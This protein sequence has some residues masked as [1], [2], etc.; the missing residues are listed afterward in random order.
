MNKSNTIILRGI[1][2]MNVEPKIA[3]T[4]E[5]LLQSINN[6]NDKVVEPQTVYDKIPKIY[7]KNTW[8]KTTNLKCWKCDL[9]FKGIP[10]FIATKSLRDPTGNFCSPGCA[11]LYIDTEADPIHKWEMEMQLKFLH[12]E[13][14]GQTNVTIY[15]A[16]N[17]TRRQ[18][19]GGDL[20]EEQFI[21]LVKLC[22]VPNK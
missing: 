16:P 4:N 20:T 19:Y 11:R 14:T 9:F 1:Y 12:T 21:S 8:I 15:P 10:Y 22:V 6:N 17:K 5:K 2:I 3:K 7:D 18:E 13:L